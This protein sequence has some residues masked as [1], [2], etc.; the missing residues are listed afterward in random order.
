MAP[1]LPTTGTHRRTRARTATRGSRCRAYAFGIALAGM[2]ACSS[3]HRHIAIR[4]SRFLRTNARTFSEIAW[5]AGAAR[6]DPSHHSLAANLIATMPV[7]ALFLTI[8]D[9]QR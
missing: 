7:N 8:D 2:Y 6:F 3:P 5:D 4:R 1:A 9:V